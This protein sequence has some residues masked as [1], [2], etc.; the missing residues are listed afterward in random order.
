MVIHGSS[1]GGFS[2]TLCCGCGGWDL[3]A[4]NGLAALS[5][6]GVS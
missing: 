1:S 5:E 3:D 4:G 6:W 2:W